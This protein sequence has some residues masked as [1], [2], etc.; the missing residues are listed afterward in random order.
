MKDP[1]IPIVADNIPI[2]YPIIIGG[3]TLIYKLEE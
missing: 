1:P 2:K 3:M